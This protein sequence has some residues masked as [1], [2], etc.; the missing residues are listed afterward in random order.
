MTL[1]SSRLKEGRGE[2]GAPTELQGWGEAL[3]WNTVMGWL[4]AAW[5]AL[6][7][8]SPGRLTWNGG[9]DRW[10]DGVGLLHEGLDA[11]DRGADRVTNRRL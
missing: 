9:R 5:G 4:P 7:E 2:R 8:G 10:L 11:G 1:L 6:Q 3:P